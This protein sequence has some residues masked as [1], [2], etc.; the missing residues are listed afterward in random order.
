VLLD[1]TVLK[2]G[3]PAEVMGSEEFREVFG[4]AAF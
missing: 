4:Y 2:E 3:P 1:R